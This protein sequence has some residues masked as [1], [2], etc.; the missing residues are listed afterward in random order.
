MMSSAAAIVNVTTAT[1]RYISRRLAALR[2]TA[3]AIGVDVRWLMA[4]VGRSSNADGGGR[5]ADGGWR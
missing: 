5:I 4:V 2:R 3:R 1:T